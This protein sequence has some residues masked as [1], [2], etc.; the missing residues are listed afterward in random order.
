MTKIQIDLSEVEDKIVE[1]YKLVYNLKTK[2]EAIKEMV[3]Y[4]KVKIVP[5][6]ISKQEEYYKKAL[7]SFLQA[8][9]PDEEAGSARSG[10]RDIQVSYYIGLAYETLHNNAKAKSYY[11]LAAEQTIRRTGYMSY[12]QGLSY[13]KLGN[14]SK[15]REIFDSMIAEGDRQ[16][17]GSGPN[18]DFFA[19]FGERE[20]EN[21][22]KSQAYTLRGLGYKGLGQADLATQDLK[23]AV[24]L[25]VSNLWAMAELQS[26]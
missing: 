1:A 17:Q 12:Y 21:T 23:Q 19:I 9:I 24:N 7:N 4:F 25:S 13:F 26:N 3:K 8:Q 18:V 6:R 20:S 16:I 22:R 5:E 11:K 2:Q 15:A 10:N 14:K